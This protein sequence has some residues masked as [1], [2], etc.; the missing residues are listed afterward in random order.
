MQAFEQLEQSFAAWAGV[1]NPVAC[2]NGTAALH[3]ALE[4]L[5]L[6]LG[7]EVLVPEFTMVACARAVV[8]AGLKP[9]FV[10]CGEDLL[11]NVELIGERI[12]PKTRA[13]LPVHVYGRRC[14]VDAVMWWAHTNHLQVVEDLAEAHGI[15][16]HSETDAACWSFYQNKIIAGEEGGL[17]SFRDPEKAALAKMLRCQGFAEQHDFLHVPRG[18]NYR[19]SNANANLVL[20]SLRM[21]DENLISRKWVEAWYDECVPEEY[22]QPSRLVPWVYDIRVR[23]MQSKQQNEIVRKL[24]AA[25]V[26]V[27][28]GFK[29]MSEQPE[30]MESREATTLRAFHL[31]QEVLYFPISPGLTKLDVRR[32][33]DLFL[34]AIA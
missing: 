10:D 3:L 8:L 16:P 30:F 17:V 2:A 19:L 32:H 31:S 34:E 29:P 25:G 21:A 22:H 13:I 11:L 15:H 14:D 1:E 20:N 23:G 18:H 26:A 33:V 4:A 12:T 28:H 24:N 6:P 27:R 7:S 9:V 5:R